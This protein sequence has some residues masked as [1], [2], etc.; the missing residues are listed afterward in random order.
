M[1]G[2]NIYRVWGN[3][4]TRCFNKN[5][6]NYKNYGSRGITICDEWRNDFMSFYNWAITNGYNNNLSIDRINNDGNYEP[7]NCRWANKNTQLQNTRKI[8][9]NNTS[10]YRGASFDKNKKKFTS[11]IM[12]NSKS[13]KL[14]S[15]NTLIEAGYA[16]DKYVIDNN[17]KHT[18]NGLCVKHLM[19]V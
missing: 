13:I 1:T 17:L 6:I 8:R 14:G 10:G 11:R 3:I 9:I 16:Y 19:S 7:N 5:N 18:T 15:F 12:V 2:T 4:K